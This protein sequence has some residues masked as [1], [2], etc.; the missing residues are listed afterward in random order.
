[1]Y[2]SSFSLDAC[3]EV[4]LT[5][6]KA[7]TIAGVDPG[8]SHYYEYVLKTLAQA[9]AS[10]DVRQLLTLQTKELPEFIRQ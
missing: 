1:M 9:V 10:T 7:L 3:I 2:L 5:L 6:V 4:T 8:I